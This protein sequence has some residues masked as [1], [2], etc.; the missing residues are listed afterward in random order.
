[1]GTATETTI[2]VGVGTVTAATTV[3][4]RRLYGNDGVGEG[5]EWRRAI[6][7]TGHE[8][9]GILHVSDGWCR[10]DA[11]VSLFDGSL[12]R[13]RSNN[14]SMVATTVEE[15]TPNGCGKISTPNG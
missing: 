9:G 11:V 2:W 8:D 5:T 15:A 13:I 14:Q 12:I 3:S 7:S 4:G 1:M 6:R 10:T